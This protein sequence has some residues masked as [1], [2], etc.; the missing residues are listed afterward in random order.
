MI[1]ELRRAVL[2]TAI[3]MLLLGGGYNAVIWTVGRTAFP[4]QAGGSLIRRQDGTV[5][6][7]RLIAQRFTRPE[8]FHSRPSGV[9]YNAA[10]AG[11]SNYG[12]SHPDHLT[13]VRERLA[14]ITAL[15]GVPASR[16]PSEMVTA[17]GSGLDPHIPPQ[18]AAIQVNRVAAARGVSA[19][20]VQALI[21]ANTEPP[22][23]GV[24]GRSRVNVLA[25]N[26]ALDAAFGPPRG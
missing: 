20:Q 19:T 10:S 18:A 9:D 1:T 22:W 4:A 13:A 23:L 11:G 16:V 24:F 14:G 8:Y 6:G 3:T 12:P 7:S 26:L 5:A 25:L 15:E 17:G 2:F 21:E